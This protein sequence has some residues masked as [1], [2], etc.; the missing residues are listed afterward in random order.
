MV[1]A[2][3]GLELR[4]FTLSHSTS[5][6]FAKGFRDRVSRTICSGWLQTAILLIFASWVARITG[7]SHQLFGSVNFLCFCVLYF[8]GFC[9]RNPTPTLAL[10]LPVVLRIEPRDL[11]MLDECSST[12][13]IPP[14]PF[15]Y[16]FLP[17]CIMGFALFPLS[18]LEFM[19]AF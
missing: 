7:T 6:I 5:P 19:L 2:V 12:W 1:F 9:P 4:V 11:C 8:T 18:K 15:Y 17:L 16:Y 3:L 13:A 10:F 14:F